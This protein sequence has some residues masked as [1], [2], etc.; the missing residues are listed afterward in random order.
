MELALIAGG[1]ME[2]RPYCWLP[3]ERGYL[4]FSEAGIIP[5]LEEAQDSIRAF[6]ALCDTKAERPM[7]AARRA[8]DRPVEVVLQSGTRQTIDA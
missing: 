3:T 4:C 2:D 1:W 7:T 6:N 5:S 8:L